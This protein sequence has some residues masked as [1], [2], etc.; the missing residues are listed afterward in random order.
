MIRHPAL[1]A[2]ALLVGCAG[3]PNAH[4]A[5]SPAEAVDRGT[6]TAIPARFTHCPTVASGTGILADGDFHEAPDPGYYQTYYKGQGFAP[7]WK[8]TTESIDLYGGTVNKFPG[9]VCSIDLDGQ[10]AGGI[11]HAL[12][13]T[14]KGAMYT[15][16]FWFSGNDGAG[17]EI[18]NMEVE[19]AG[20]SETLQWNDANGGPEN[21]DYDSETWSFTAASASTTLRFRSLD[22]KNDSH[23]PVVAA[24]AVTQN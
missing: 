22:A 13:R 24:I 6:F 5:F 15:V 19:A 23:R 18:K 4:S 10:Q 11:E 21:G 16:S 12:F 14:T 2:A 20:Q 9:G 17:P 7:G 1:V 3:V 8:V